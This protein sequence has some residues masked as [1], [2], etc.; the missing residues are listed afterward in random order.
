MTDYSP[1]EPESL[2]PALEAI[3]ETELGL[4]QLRTAIYRYRYGLETD[5]TAAQRSIAA[6]IRQ[7]LTGW[8][9]LAHSLG[10]QSEGSQRQPRTDDD[11]LYGFM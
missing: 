2:D 10:W 11:N 6:G 5:V 3:G 1:P 9:K 8:D 7:H 4:R